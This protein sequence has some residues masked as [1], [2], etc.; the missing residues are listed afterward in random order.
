VKA[1]V[2]GRSI[3]DGVDCLTGWPAGETI[4]AAANP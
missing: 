2:G 3:R 4:D 1:R